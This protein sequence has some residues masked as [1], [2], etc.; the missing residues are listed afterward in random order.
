MFEIFYSSSKLLKT[1]TGHKSWVNSIDYSTLD[2]NQFICSGSGDNTIRIWDVDTGQQIRSLN[3]HS[4]SVLCAKFSPYHY[5]NNRRSV[6]CS[7]SHDSTICFWDIK[8]NQQLPVFNEH[9]DSVCDIVF[10]SFN[11]GRYMCSG[12][13]DNTI[14]LWD[15]ETS[16]SLHVFNGHESGVLCV[17]ISPLQSNNNGK[18]DNCV[19]MIGGNGYTICSGSLDYT[20]RIWDIETTKQS[21]VFEGHEDY[22]M[23]VRYGSNELRNIGSANTILSGSVDK[24]VCL[25]DI[26]SGQQIQ[27]FNKHTVCVNAV[28]YSPF[29][30]NNIEIGDNSNVIC[31][32]SEDNTIRFWDIRL[33]KIEL[34]VINGSNECDGIRCLK[35]LQL[36]KNRKS[37]NDSFICLCYGSNKGLIQICG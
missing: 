23:S 27:V 1:F 4:C 32:G 21:I 30:V 12:S 36:K 25:W 9:N 34:Y 18:N 35:F 22:V 3:G 8:E 11:Y 20:I 13:E 33:N 15:V 2:G 14:R 37:N 24:S 26:R 7:S 6:I 19:G 17:D 29:I 5:Y 16:K 10:S 28:E 31:S